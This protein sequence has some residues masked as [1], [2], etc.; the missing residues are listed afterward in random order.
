[1]SGPIS[2]DEAKQGHSIPSVVFDVVNTLLSRGA[3]NIKQ[4]EVVRLI[5]ASGIERSVI[6]ENHYLDFEDAYRAN[7]WSVEYDRPGFNETYDAC[8]VFSR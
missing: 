7:G 1:M 6:F 8:W 2:P 3:R 4:S 5:E